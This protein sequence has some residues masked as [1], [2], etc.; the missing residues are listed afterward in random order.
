MNALLWVSFAIVVLS[1]LVALAETT[2]WQVERSKAD[3]AVRCVC[4]F[5]WAATIVWFAL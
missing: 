5:A 4:L 3:C 1:G 2:G